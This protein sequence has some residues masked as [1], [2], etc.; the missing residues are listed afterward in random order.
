MKSLS[1]VVFSILFWL[2]C[3]CFLAPVT[4]ATPTPTAASNVVLEATDESVEIP[5]LWEQVISVARDGTWQS[6]G[7]LLAAIGIVVAFWIYH[8][9]S[10][11]SLSYAVL[12]QPLVTVSTKEIIGRVQVLLDGRPIDSPRLLLLKIENT[13]ELAIEAKDFDHPLTVTVNGEII[14]CYVINASSNSLRECVKFKL[15]EDRQLKFDNMLLNSG[16]WFEVQILASNMM[17]NK[18][19]LSLQARIV[20][21]NDVRWKAYATAT[22]D[23]S[24]LNWAVYIVALI[25]FMVL[26]AFILSRSQAITYIESNP[27]VRSGFILGLL[28]STG[29]FAIWLVLIQS[30]KRYLKARLFWFSLIEQVNALAKGR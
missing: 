17:D 18:L 28:L 11:K 24:V 6:I 22:Q 29:I 14:N 1:P 16:D 25:V 12:S 3:F 19:P 9:Q 2:T 15:V 10:H 26:T 5:N 30:Y 4:A 8:K 23:Y 13:G 21:V 7:A 27:E 20:G